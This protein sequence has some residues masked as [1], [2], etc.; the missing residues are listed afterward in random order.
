MHFLLE[1]THGFSQSRWEIKMQPF[2]EKN[3]RFHVYSDDAERYYES[4]I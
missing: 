1:I 4:S 3:G 2:L